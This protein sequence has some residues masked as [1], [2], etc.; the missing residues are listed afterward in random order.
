MAYIA[1][2]LGIFIGDN[3][4]KNSV[5]K[6]R[7]AGK[8][9]TAARGCLILRKYHNKGACMNLGERRRW[10]VAAISVILTAAMTCVFAVTLTGKGN[11]WLRLGLSF[12]LGGAFS[13]TYDR[14]KRGYVVDYF[15]FNVKWDW[16]RQ[17]VFNI[18]DF[19][20]LAGSMMIAIGGEMSLP[21]SN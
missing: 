17:I 6:K 18:S 20:I 5:E 4:L 13:N 21:A 3:R 16:L 12:L 19:C 8:D 11:R 14:L 15:S 7:D 9:E 1:L 10:L 2:I